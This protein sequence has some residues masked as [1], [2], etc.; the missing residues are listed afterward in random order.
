M[1]VSFT[2]TKSTDYVSLS[3]EKGQV[4]QDSDLEPP[5]AGDEPEIPVKGKKLEGSLCATSRNGRAL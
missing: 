1:R 3:K 5:T 4:E 2:C